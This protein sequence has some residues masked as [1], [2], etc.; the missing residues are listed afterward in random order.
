MP[1][2]QRE[3][4]GQRGFYPPLEPYRTGRLAVS[5]LHELYFEECGNP[6]GKPAVFLHGGPGA[7]LVPVYR[8]AFDPARYRLVL[9]DQRG[10]GRSTPRG[11]LREN[12]TWDLVADIE[13]LRAHLGIERWLVAG[14]SWGG[15]LALAYAETHPERV[16][17]MILRGVALWRD[18]EHDWTLKEGANWFFPE[19]WARFVAMIPTAE[20]GDL[21]RAY[22]ERL[23]SADRDVRS[24]AARA[25]GEWESAIVS[26]VPDAQF[27]AAHAQAYEEHLSLIECHYTV[28]RA[29]LRT[30]TQLLDDL[31]R[32][33]HIPSVAVFGRY[34]AIT[35][36]KIG[37]D[38]KARWPELDLVVLPDAG[39]AFTEPGI[40]REMVRASDRFAIAV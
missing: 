32:V 39:H 21:A 35:P 8:Q 17:E 30:D 20:R 33:R 2:E 37:W 19:A 4:T 1:T 11:E 31:D 7:G 5:A 13:A 38:M 26:L 15:T 29:W 25:W 24:S 3:S 10:A 12:T 23:T 28:N 14:G 9:L 22:Y 27:V 34:D 36:V 18:A 16:T 40:A 6:R